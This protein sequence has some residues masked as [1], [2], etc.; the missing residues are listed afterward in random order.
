[1]INFTKSVVVVMVVVVSVNLM[2]SVFPKM[3]FFSFP[4]IFLSSSLEM[5]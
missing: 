4:F 2:Y 5:D 1:M 3:S